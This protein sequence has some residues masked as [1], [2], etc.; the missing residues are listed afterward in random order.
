MLDQSRD[1]LRV[2]T[3]SQREL[4]RE[5]SAIIAGCHGGVLVYPTLVLLRSLM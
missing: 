1:R 4:F 2:F 5:P 3:C